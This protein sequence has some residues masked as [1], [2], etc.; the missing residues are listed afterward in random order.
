MPIGKIIPDWSGRLQKEAILFCTD[1]IHSF[2]HSFFYSF[3][4][5]SYLAMFISI[6]QGVLSLHIYLCLYLP[7]YLYFYPCNS[8]HIYLSLHM[9]LNI[10]FRV[11]SIEKLSATSDNQV[12]FRLSLK[13]NA[14]SHFFLHFFF[15][16]DIAAKYRD[17]ANGDRS[18][19]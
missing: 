2:L 17:I 3:I 1:F 10:S 14:R 15:T 7:I 4:Y 12:H 5:S 9:L 13:R 8:V 6:Y 11:N 16:S 18:K 19:D